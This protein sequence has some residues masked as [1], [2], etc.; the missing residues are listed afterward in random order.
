MSIEIKQVTNKKMLKQFI[1]F[2]DDL[3]KDNPYYVPT[4][5]IDEMNTFNRK[6]NVNYG[7]A[8]SVEFLAYKDNK[9]VGRI[10]G[11]INRRYNELKNVKHLRFNHLDFIDDLE[12]S[13]ALFDAIKKWGLE[14]GMSEFNGPIGITDFDKQGMLTSGYDIN[15]MFITN[16]NYDYYPKHMEA[17]GFKVD[18]DWVEYLIPVPKEDDER[19]KKI[20]HLN[21]RSMQRFGFKLVKP[22]NKKD[23]QK[24]IDPL[25]K[26]YNDAFA[27]LH[28]VTRLEQDQIDMYVKNFFGFINLDYV[29]IVTDKDDNLI[30]IGVLAPNM[31][32]AMQKSKGR[33][34]PFGFIH[35]LKGLKHPEGLDM[36]F[37]AVSPEYQGYGIN[38]IMMIDIIENARKNGIKFAETGPELTGNE[39]VQA[40]WKNFDAKIIRTRRCYIKDI[41]D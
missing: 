20:K 41:K 10:S 40:M 23:L 15:G 39:K 34:F 8:E 3:Y 26:I 22:K 12:V 32:K 33:L 19:L 29:S 17:L 30:G 1:K 25:F 31:T 36:F 11:L 7:F 38:G 2:G 21:E 37:V 5:F 35:L 6:K 27:P 18:V 28:G 14:K 16:Y 4:L 13:K 9:I 24:W